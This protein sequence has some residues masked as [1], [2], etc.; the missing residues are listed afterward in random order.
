MGWLQILPVG[1]KSSQPFQFNMMHILPSSKIPFTKVPLDMMISTKLTFLKKKSKMD[2]DGKN[3]SLKPVHA[4]EKEAVD[5]G[6][7]LL[8]EYP[9]DHAIFQIGN[10]EFNQDG[11]QYGYKKL[12][13]FL[14]L[15]KNPNAGLTMI[16]TQKWMFMSLLHQ[17]YHREQGIDLPEAKQDGG[18]PVYLDGFA[19][20]GILNLQDVMQNW[21]ATA[22]IG[23]KQHSVLEALKLQATEP[24]KPEVDETIGDLNF[25]QDLEKIE[26]KK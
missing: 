21:P 8:D 16:V 4:N 14:G 1:Y 11:L 9:F 23:V 2:K 12:Y 15:D 10:G 5:M 20:S 13:N 19:Y 25:D 22:G 7:V 18:I 17:P 24:P 26:S 6:L 3:S